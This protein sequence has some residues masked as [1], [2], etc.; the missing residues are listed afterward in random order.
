MRPV[1]ANTSALLLRITELFVY[2]KV[3]EDLA[4]LREH[5]YLSIAQGHAVKTYIVALCEELAESSVRI[6]DAIALPNRLIGSPF[7]MR[8]GQVY[9][10][11]MEAVEGAK[12]CYDKGGLGGEAAG[13]ATLEALGNKELFLSL[14]RCIEV[15][16]ESNR[17]VLEVLGFLELW[18]FSAAPVVCLSTAASPTPTKF[19]IPSAI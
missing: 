6:I 11:F 15:V 12:E 1:C 3:E 14:E 17:S 10:H 2:T 7:G 16:M 5:D 13:P 4:V 18:I 19:G 9:R 8:D